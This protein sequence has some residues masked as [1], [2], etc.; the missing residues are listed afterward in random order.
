MKTEDEHYKYAY[1]DKWA[2]DGVFLNRIFDVFQQ[3]LDKISETK[4]WRNGES[5][6]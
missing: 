1:L 5:V 3:F 6:K 4:K 2:K